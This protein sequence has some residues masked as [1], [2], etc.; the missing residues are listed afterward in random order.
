MSVNEG[1]LHLL[2]F[3]MGIIG[4]VL[5]EVRLPFALLSSVARRNSD[6]RLIHRF[7]VAQKGPLAS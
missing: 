1:D 6:M 3:N 7:F 4:I 5:E 2:A